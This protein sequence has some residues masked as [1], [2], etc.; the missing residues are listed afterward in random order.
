MNYS[1]YISAYAF[2]WNVK[3]KKNLAAAIVTA[4]VVIS[5]RG[6]HLLPNQRVIFSK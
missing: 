4:D 6:R 3:K 2:D 5:F 1:C